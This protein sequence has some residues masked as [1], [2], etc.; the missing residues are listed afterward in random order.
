MGPPASGGTAKLVRLMRSAWLVALAHER[1]ASAHTLRAYGDDVERF[2]AF[3]HTHLG[4]AANEKSLAK[5][6]P[7]DIRAFITVRRSEGLGAKG[8]QRALAAVRSFFRYLARENILENAA[9]RR[10]RSR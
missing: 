9:A 2:L 10:G 3:L 8:V 4:G 5:L 1:R 6:S 7:A